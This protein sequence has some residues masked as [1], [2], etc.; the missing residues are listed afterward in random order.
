MIERYTRPEMAAIWNE[1]AK[2]RRMLDVEIAACE[3]WTKKGLITQTELKKIKKNASFSL[4]R[5]KEIEQVTNHDVIAFIESIEENLGP[6]GRWVHYGLTSSDVLDTGLGMAMRDAAGVLLKALKRC[7]KVLAQQARK[8]K[9]QA[10]IGR[11]HGIHAEPTSLGMKFALWY[12]ETQRNIQRLEQAQKE[13]AY[14]KVSGAV[15]TYS[16]SDPSIELYVCKK[17]KLKPSPISTQII[18]RD[19]HAYYMETIG[20]IAASFE[21]FSTEIRNLQR[22]DIREIEEP[23]KKGQKGSS[24]MPHKRNPI[25]S[26]R[27]SGLARVIRGYVVTAL[28][29]V[30]L[31]HERDISHS[32]TERIIIPDATILLD[33]MIDKFI[34]IVNNLSVFPDRMQE[35]LN[36]MRGLIFSQK[37]LLALIKSGLSRKEAYVL[38]Q[39]NAMKVWEKPNATLESCLLSD[40]EVMQR[41]SPREIKMIFDIKNYLRYTDK[42]YKRLGLER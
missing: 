27:I 11:T 3:A 25:T 8:Y 31:W 6:E 28:E 15:G 22:T 20:L 14:G 41:L 19:R 12:A 18:Q 30:T 33:Y 38:V 42:I 23:F 4:K 32:S 17:L 29:N 1:E 36:R 37:M 2:F 40:S 9:N 39:R 10:M 16:Q 7:V 34:N 26:E 21:K 5:I 35:N 13:I 24:A